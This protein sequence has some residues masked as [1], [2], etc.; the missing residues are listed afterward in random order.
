MNI[1]VHSLRLAGVFAIEK[2]DQIFVAGHGVSE[3]SQHV[4]QLIVTG[5]QK[6]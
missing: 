5:K 3:A 4:A 1:P 6:L 2:Y